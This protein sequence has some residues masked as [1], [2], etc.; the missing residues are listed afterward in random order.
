VAA[1]GGGDL[2]SQID[3]EMLKRNFM[4]SISVCIWFLIVKYAVKL[5][6]M[7]HTFNLMCLQSFISG[8]RRNWEGKQH[9]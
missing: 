7:V 5:T 3:S 8:V 4:A 6:S 9:H 1:V 2:F